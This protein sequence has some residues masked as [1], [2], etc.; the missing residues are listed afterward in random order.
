[1]AAKV[2]L[3]KWAARDRRHHAPRV[4]DSVERRDERWNEPA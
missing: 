4:P 1:M 2:R 3:D